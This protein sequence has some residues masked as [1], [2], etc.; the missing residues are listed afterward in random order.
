MQSPHKLDLTTSLQMAKA[1]YSVYGRRAFPIANQKRGEARLTEIAEFKTRRVCCCVGYWQSATRASVV[2]AFRGSANGA[3]WAN[4]AHLAAWQPVS[5]MIAGRVHPGFTHSLSEVWD[6]VAEAIQGLCQTHLPELLSGYA[7]GRSV[8]LCFTGH[9]RGGALAVLAGIRALTTFVLPVRVVTFGAP[10]VGD[11]DFAAAYNE[12]FRQGE[13]AH[14]RFECEG[15]PV[16]VFPFVLQARH[17]GSLAYLQP[18]SR[19]VEI[20][21]AER[22]AGRRVLRTVSMKSSQYHRMTMYLHLLSQAVAIEIVPTL[23]SVRTRRISQSL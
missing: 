9:S 3:E 20:I 8:P 14:W 21:G 4:N 13:S 5:P 10:R 22:H 17:T 12:I 19:I 11:I 16:P 1:A 7:A 2:V 15:D 23:T 6:E 18:G